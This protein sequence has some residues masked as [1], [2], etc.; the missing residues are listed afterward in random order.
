MRERISEILAARTKAVLME[1]GRQP[2]AVM[3]LLVPGDDGYRVV[4]NLRT[5][6]VEH[7]KGEV[8]F[9]G[10]AFHDGEDKDLMD[11]ALRETWEEMGIPPEN[12]EVLG[13]LDDQLTRPPYVIRP[14]LGTIRE[15]QTYQPAAIE[16]AEVL[17]IPLRWLR[18]PANLIDSDQKPR[19]YA[20]REVRWHYYE[21]GDAVIWGA[22]CR[23]TQHV[24]SLLPPDIE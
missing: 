17:E 22:T 2:S 20:G 5:S 8:S 1:E 3:V 4:Y 15:P 19:E 6:H 12:I 7:F 14:Y 16:V 13:E 11:T 21:W 9:P 18:D 24:L 23:I 10:G